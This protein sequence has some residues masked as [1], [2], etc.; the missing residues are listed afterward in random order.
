MRELETPSVRAR[1]GRRELS[2]GRH[3]PSLL[4]SRT[5]QGLPG[6]EGV[7]EV[8]LGGALAVWEPDPLPH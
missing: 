4:G 6:E 7:L 3:D 1:R 8:G 2:L 5:L